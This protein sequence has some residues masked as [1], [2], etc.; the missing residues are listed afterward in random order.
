MVKEELFRL[1]G[2]EELNEVSV[3]VLGRGGG[4]SSPSHFS[5][6]IRAPLHLMLP[7]ATRLPREASGIDPRTL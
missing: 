1:L 6:I 4:F 7:P 5:L 2:C 3:L